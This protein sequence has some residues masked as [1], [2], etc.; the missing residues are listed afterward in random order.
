MLLGIESKFSD[1]YREV[2]SILKVVIRSRAFVKMID[3]GRK[4]MNERY[5]S[6]N[7]IILKISIVASSRVNVI[8]TTFIQR[9]MST[10]KIS[11][12]ANC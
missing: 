4:D 3:V 7:Y 9:L 12:T 1:N 2:C 6:P 5:L 8:S 11:L 10:Y